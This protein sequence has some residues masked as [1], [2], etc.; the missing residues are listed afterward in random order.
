MIM[1][2]VKHVEITG[3]ARF[4]L[5][6][7]PKMMEWLGVMNTPTYGLR[8]KWAGAATYEKNEYGG[9][10]AMFNYHISGAEAVAFDA[11]DQ[12][13]A[14]LK[15]AGTVSYAITIDI[16]AGGGPINLLK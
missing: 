10:T 8:I 2:N 7:D 3:S 13:V 9:M 11:L 6:E 16:E 15:R 5:H 1:S 4:D 12:L 14:A